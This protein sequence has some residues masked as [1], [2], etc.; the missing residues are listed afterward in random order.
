M[1]TTVGNLKSKD[2]TPS[3]TKINGTYENDRNAD[4]A[5]LLKDIIREVYGV[6]DVIIAHHLVYVTTEKRDDGFE[7]QIVE[8]VP[9]ADALIF[10]H[11]VAKKLWGACWRDRLIQLALEPVETRDALLASLYY[12]RVSEK[13]IAMELHGEA[14]HGVTR[15]AP[16][17]S[18]L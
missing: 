13:V 1:N 14:R 18:G 5:E 6:K 8:E 10:D 7:Y 17:S 9:S 16:T 3:G 11:G 4:C 12:G 15:A 2:F